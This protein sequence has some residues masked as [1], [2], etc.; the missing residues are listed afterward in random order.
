MTKTKN[1]ISYSRED[2]IFNVI[3]NIIIAILFVVVAYPLIF[4]IS[5]SFSSK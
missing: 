2:K 5:S 1:K 3:I 4:V